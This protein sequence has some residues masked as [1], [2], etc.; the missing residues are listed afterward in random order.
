LQRLIRYLAVMLLL[1][2]PVLAQEGLILMP[3]GTIPD[4]VGGGIGF[5]PDYVG[6]DDTF[7]G[8]L[9]VARISSGQRYLQL[10]GN[11]LYGNILDSGRLELG[12]LGTYRFGR[13]DVD[14]ALVSR[15]PEIDDTIDLGLFA[16]VKL[17]GLDDPRKRWW[18]GV[19]GQHDVLGEHQGYTVDL[20]TR[21]WWPAADW[22]QMGVFGAVT[23]GSG[24]YMSEFFDVKANDAA[25]SGLPAFDADSGF[26][27]ARLTVFLIT[28]LAPSWF[29]GGG[30]MV[31]RILGD[32]GD[33]PI[34]RVRGSA[35][36]LYGGIGVAY[37]W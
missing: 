23:Y 10:L 3:P 5:A 30:L 14:D 24:D 16:G 15:L 28:E 18:A 33:S 13:E 2:A 21:I 34:V 11:S 22:L 6:S 7:I 29:V 27:D 8:G 26:R 36:Q 12:I 37:A 17:L 9:P 1:P 4:H 32:A 25:R 19:S 31:Q 35:N 20:T